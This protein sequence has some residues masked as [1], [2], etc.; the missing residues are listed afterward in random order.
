MYL[1]FPAMLGRG[2][3]LTRLDSTM[4]QYFFPLEIR[5]CKLAM[6]LYTVMRVIVIIA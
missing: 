1:F 6:L 2:F 5:A 3:P 4:Y